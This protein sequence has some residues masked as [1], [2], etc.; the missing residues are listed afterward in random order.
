M[1][2]DDY[3]P[4]HSLQYS[5]QILCNNSAFLHYTDARLNDSLFIQQMSRTNPACIRA[6]DKE[7][8]LFLDGRN[9]RVAK[10]DYNITSR[11]GNARGCDTT[12]PCPK[13]WT[14]YNF[15]EFLIVPC[16]KN[17]YRNYLVQDKEKVCTKSHQVLNNWTKRKDIL[18]MND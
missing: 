16:P 2:L 4:K 15:Q 1:S 18:V 10:C 8:S 13:M 14:N 12:Q 17:T 6:I 5:D 7:T 11:G 3:K 9:Q